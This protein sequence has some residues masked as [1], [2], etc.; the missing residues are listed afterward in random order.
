[1]GTGLGIRLPFIL[2]QPKELLDNFP[3][4]DVSSVFSIRSLYASY[5]SSVNWRIRETGGNTEQDFN[6]SAGVMDQAA[7]EAFVGVNDGRVVDWFNQRDGIAISNATAAEQP[8]IATAGTYLAEVTYANTTN[9]ALE[10][11]DSTLRV[12]TSDYTIFIVIEVPA[13]VGG[14]NRAVLGQRFSASPTYAQAAGSTALE[15]DFQGDQYRW[16]K[17][18]PTQALI[19]PTLLTTAQHQLITITATSLAVECFLDQV[20]EVTGTFTAEPDSAQVFRI[21]AQRV[22]DTLKGFNVKEFISFTRELTSAE[23]LTVETNIKDFYGI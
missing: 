9:E 23:I 8:K 21:G 17:F 14:G 2:K 6:F 13:T 15:L 22:T 11:P 7:I 3:L 16:T 12:I 20:S 5:N 1:M 4:S 18:V 19:F 10:A